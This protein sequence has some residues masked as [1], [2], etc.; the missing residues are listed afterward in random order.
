[1][2]LTAVFKRNIQF[3]SHPSTEGILLLSCVLLSIAI[4]NLPLGSSFKQLLNAVIGVHTSYIHLQYSV[5]TW[6]NDALMAVFFLMAGLEIKR[7]IVEGQLADS[8][9]AALPVLCAIGGMLVPAFIYFLFNRNTNTANGWGIP[10]ATDI[11]FAVAILNAVKKL[12]PP[13][14]KVFL[15]ALAIVDDLGAIIVIAVFYTGGI[16]LTN[17]MCAAAVFVLMLVFNKLE[18]RSIWF[19]LV[20]GMFM[21]YFV[22]HSGIHATIAGVLTALA[23]PVNTRS[24][25]TLSASLE[26]KLTAPVNLLILPL[27]ALANT[28]IKFEAGMFSKLIS[29]LGLGIMV[30]LVLGKPAGILLMAFAAVK[31]KIGKLPQG[32]N[33]VHVGGMGLLAGVGFTMSVFISLLSFSNTSYQ[34]EAKFA[35]LVAS[36]TAA[37]AGYCV[38]KAYA[39][40]NANAGSN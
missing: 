3:I 25:L 24:G 17:L 19:Y 5:N 12:I 27:F 30:G 18:V 13:S 34:T 22:H 33:W 20:P 31:A 2:K 40:N 6:I 8:K 26:H 14:L 15:T 32:V 4:A 36:V 10:M 37:L 38:L 1:M 28:N 23:I 11:A 16:Q 21:W 7:E 35:V 29:P 9:T 39:N